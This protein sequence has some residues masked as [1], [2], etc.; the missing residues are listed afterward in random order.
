MKSW[1]LKLGRFAGIEVFIHWTFWII[2]AWILLMH[3]QIG[4]GLE[5]GIWGVFFVL[6][7]FACVVLHEFGHA[8]T[9]RRFGIATK[10]ITLYPIGGIASL[11]RM[12]EKPW[13]ELLV[14][15]AGPA[16][17]AL[18]AAVLWLYLNAAGQIPDLSAMKESHSML[19]VP[20]LWGLYAANVVLAAFNL[21]PAFPM[22]G[23][24]ALRAILAFSVP[25]S[26]AT[27]MAAGVGQFL[28]IIFVFLG[29]FYNFWLVFIGLFVYLGAGF[30]ASQEHT[31]TLLSGLRVKDA[32]IKRFTVLDPD[33]TLEEA[34]SSLLDSQ[35]TEFLVSDD[36]RPVGILSKNDIYRG[37]SEKGNDAMIAEVMDRD[38]YVVSAEMT[39][40]DFFGEVLNKG[41]DVAV[42]MDD[43]SLLGLIDR[44]NIEEKLLIREAL[45]R[46]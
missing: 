34:V 4:H 15:L 42:V 28:A 18:I 29:F 43:S 44:A 33:M 23:G 30:E 12:P 2:I 20:F 32:L 13:Q 8:L 9:A 24:R 40:Q 21:I 16:V 17:N 41:K 36:D 26:Q 46:V 3:F 39:L 19:E 14:A 6:V 45:R 10:Q 1:S 22:D 27:R 37:L 5:Q 35:D 25:R 31:Q 7:L 11:E 38:F